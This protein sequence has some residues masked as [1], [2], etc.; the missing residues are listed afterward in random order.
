M[1]VIARCRPICEYK[2]PEKRPFSNKN[3][4]VHK[5]FKRQIAL[6]KDSLRIIDRMNQQPDASELHRLAVELTV[7]C[8]SILDIRDFID[9]YDLFYYY[10]DKGELDL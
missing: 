10:D 8:N 7:V 3:G 5:M 6:E 4:V 9:T 2:S 1:Y